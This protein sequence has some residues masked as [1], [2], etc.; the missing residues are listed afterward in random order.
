MGFSTAAAVATDVGASVATDAVAT[1][2]GASII[3][4]SA[5]D[6]F[7]T[8]ALDAGGS[9]IFSGITADTIGTSALDTSIGSGLT[10]EFA[11]GAAGSGG[12]LLSSI[13]SNL[14]AASGI[15]SQ[16]GQVAGAI[17]KPASTL[18]AGNAAYETGLQ[19]AQNQLALAQ[20]YDFKSNEAIF[21]SKVADANYEYETNKSVS[22]D[23]R[24]RQQNIQ[25]IGSEAAVQGASGVDVNSGSAV[26]TRVANANNGELNVL[27]QNYEATQRERADLIQEQDQTT[28]A[29]QYSKA[30]SQAEQNSGLYSAAASTKL[31][32]A[33]VSSVIQGLNALPD[34]V[35][36]GSKLLSML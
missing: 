3:D 2:V 8:S 15:A 36:S 14:G 12:D 24:L 7:S 4:T 35:N 13:T 19:S 26:D 29:D 1:D 28:Q 6:A 11:A 23:A 32:N 17:L 20:Q 18:Q 9:S 10:G 16:V 30:A 31:E 33:R 22:D 21:N 5:L 27:L 34:F 25:T